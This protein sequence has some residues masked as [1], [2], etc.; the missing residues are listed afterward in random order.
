[1]N[2]SFRKIFPL[3][4]RKIRQIFLL[5]LLFALPGQTQTRTPKLCV[6]VA[7][8][9]LDDN[10]V[11]LEIYYNIAR[12]SL[13]FQQHNSAMTSH[14]QILTFVVENSAFEDSLCYYDKE[15]EKVVAY[16]KK[17][18][19]VNPLD[20]L[21]LE[22]EISASDSLLAFDKLVE[23]NSV[24]IKEG[25]YEL[26]VVLRDLVSK[27]TSIVQRGV[28]V[29]R[30]S[31]EQLQL[32]DIEFAYSIVKAKRD[33]TKFDKWGYRV[34]PSSCL[35]FGG[36]FS[37]IYLYCE[38]YNLARIKEPSLYGFDIHYLIHDGRGKVV[39]EDTKWNV[40]SEG[41][42]VF[43]NGNFDVSD[44]PPGIYRFEVKVEDNKSGK[45]ARASKAFFIAQ[46][47][48]GE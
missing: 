3:N 34:F 26:I 46:N 27:Q 28:E 5:M 37:K 42:F 15:K 32:S 2:F 18:L 36:G 7:R 8:F 33:S 4:H 44:L 39:K 45:K 25:Y 48:M 6:D 22:D 24:K 17:K 16:K 13:T 11:Y 19:R 10:T 20:T 41:K 12:N 29:K 40:E 31:S 43:V 14:C 47:S 1:M 9:R 23:Q 30:Y 21:Y 38:I 35:E